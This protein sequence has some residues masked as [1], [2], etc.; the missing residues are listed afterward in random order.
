MDESLFL[1]LCLPWII[2]LVFSP[3][4]APPVHQG[5]C[6]SSIFFC[7]YLSWGH[8]EE[9]VLSIH[10]L[11]ILHCSLH[12]FH[13]TGKQPSYFFNLLLPFLKFSPSF[14]PIPQFLLLAPLFFWQRFCHLTFHPPSFAHP[15]LP[16][17][18]SFHQPPTIY[19]VGCWGLETIVGGGVTIWKR[20]TETL[21]KML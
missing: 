1:I 8:L 9:I 20:V 21:N 2:L 15:F 17:A 4:W 14:C 6:L 10:P 13:L 7:H 18:P 12:F 16:V 3:L 11:A 5:D 19:I